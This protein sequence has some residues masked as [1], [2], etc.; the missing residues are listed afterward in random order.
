MKE[1]DDAEATHKATAK[2]FAEV[3][4]TSA[5]LVVEV[6]REEASQFREQV[7]KLASRVS[8]STEASELEAG[9]ALFRGELRDYSQK[10]GGH[11]RQ[12]REELDAAGTAM[13]SFVDGVSSSSGE[14]ET[15]LRREF[16]H[17][18]RAAEAD[19][20][21]TVRASIH[22]TVH[23]VSQSFENL[24][25]ANALNIAQLRDEIRVLQ[26]EL[27]RGK[28]EPE[29]LAAIIPKRALDTEIDELL[30]LDQEFVAVLMGLPDQEKLYERFRKERVDTALKGLLTN[31][32]RLARKQA[33]QASMSE[34]STGV[35]GV[36]MPAGVRIEDWQTQ[37]A[38]SH[39]FQVDGMPRT[40]RIDPRLEAVGRSVGES[41]TLFFSR[42]S[43]AT[44]HVSKAV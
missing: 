40:L 9:R 34:W 12:L 37:L 4:A 8:A 39:V 31:A 22:A 29:V 24:K 26:G 3:V 14:Y 36:V 35:Y 20:V 11:L 1:L 23:T 38:V 21:R 17:L 5:E 33:P 2:M 43:K 30:R 25:R 6:D 41:H 28:S 10:A 15:V 27:Q 16:E 44:E 13:R 18:E 42:L 32:T 19:D 7:L